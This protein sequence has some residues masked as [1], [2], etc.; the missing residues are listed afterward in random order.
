MSNV[1]NPPLQELLKPSLSMILIIIFCI[2]NT[3]CMVV[4][5]T[6]KIIPYISVGIECPVETYLRNYKFCF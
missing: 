6:Q 1:L 4:D 2:N 3:L 5:E